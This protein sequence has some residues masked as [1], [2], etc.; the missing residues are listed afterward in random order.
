MLSDLVTRNDEQILARLSAPLKGVCPVCEKLVT[1]SHHGAIYDHKSCA[2]YAA[3]LRG[4]VRAGVPLLQSLPGGLDLIK[5]VVAA[6]LRL[7]AIVCEFPND[8]AIWGESL[9]H[10]HNVLK[11]VPMPT[12]QQITTGGTNG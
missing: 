11:A 6:A 5:N 10:L 7:D 4:R 12:S 8:P 3:Q 2:G 1:R 9:D